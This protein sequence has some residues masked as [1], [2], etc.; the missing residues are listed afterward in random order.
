MSH[1]YKHKQLQGHVHVHG[2]ISQHV[3]PWLQTRH[4]TVK[5]T[6]DDGR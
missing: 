2:L 6:G 4:N 5:R 1:D 3:I